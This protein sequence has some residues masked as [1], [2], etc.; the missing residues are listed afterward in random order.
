MVDLN[1]IDFWTQW[2]TFCQTIKE[3]PVYVDMVGQNGST[4]WDLFFEILEEVQ[5][6]F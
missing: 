6:K 1:K 2:H 5:A 4:S 3:N